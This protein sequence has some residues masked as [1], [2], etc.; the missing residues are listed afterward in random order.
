MFSLSFVGGSKSAEGGPNLV[1]SKSTG[2]PASSRRQKDIND[3]T[4]CP[5]HISNLG[6]DVEWSCG[7]ISRC[8]VPKEVYGR[9]KV[10]LSRFQQSIGELAGV[11]HR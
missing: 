11:Y 3:F 8:R 9:G 5:T 2:T 4:I 6:T 1:G 10:R 7:S